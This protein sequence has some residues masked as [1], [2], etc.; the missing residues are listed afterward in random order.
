MSPDQF[1]VCITIVS[2]GAKEIQ[3]SITMKV[4]MMISTTTVI[5]R[6]MIVMKRNFFQANCSGIDNIKTKVKTSDT[7][8][9]S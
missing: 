4:L 1:K 5:I 2:K 6:I 9:S 3:A 8:A 7:A